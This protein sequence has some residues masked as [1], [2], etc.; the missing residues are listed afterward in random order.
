MSDNELEIV[1]INVPTHI[2]QGES[3]DSNGTAMIMRVEDRLV[4]TMVG[5]QI[6]PL[7]D[8]FDCFSQRINNQ[9]SEVLKDYQVLKQSHI[10]KF[11]ENKIFHKHTQEVVREESDALSKRLDCF[12]DVVSTLD[13][14][15]IKGTFN[16]ET[17]I[18]A[19]REELRAERAAEREAEHEA[20]MKRILE[21]VLVSKGV[22]V[23]K[24]V[25]L[26]SVEVPAYPADAMHVD[27]PTEL[28]VSTTNTIVSESFINLGEYMMTKYAEPI[29]PPVTPRSNKVSELITKM[30][31]SHLRPAHLNLRRVWILNFFGLGISEILTLFRELGLDVQ[32]IAEVHYIK[33]DVL[34]ILIQFDYIS[35]FVKLITF[36]K[37]K[38]ETNW[39]I[40]AN[41]DPFTALLNEP[42]EHRYEARLARVL[43]NRSSQA[44]HRARTKHFYAALVDSLGST[45]SQYALVQKQLAQ[46]NGEPWKFFR[47]VKAPPSPQQMDIDADEGTINKKEYPTAAETINEPPTGTQDPDPAPKTATTQALSPLGKRRTQHAP[48]PR[49]KATLDDFIVTSAHKQNHRANRSEVKLANPMEKK[50]TNLYQALSTEETPVREGDQEIMQA[51][52]PTPSPDHCTITCL[53]PLLVSDRHNVRS[54]ITPAAT[55]TNSEQDTAKPSTDTI[56]PPIH[57]PISDKLDVRSVFSP[58]AT[59]TASEQDTAKSSTGTIKPPIHLQI[60][61]Q[62]DVRTV[63]SLAATVTECEQGTTE[64]PIPMQIA[65]QQD[66]RSVISPASVIPSVTYP[67]LEISLSSVISPAPVPSP[68]SVISSAATVSEGEQD[69]T[70]P[71]IYLPGKSQAEIA[72]PNQDQST[73]MFGDTLP[74]Y[75]C[76]TEDFFEVNDTI[77]QTPNITT[78]TRNQEHNGKADTN[79]KENVHQDTK[80]PRNESD[81]SRWQQ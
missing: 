58:T 42:E 7:V 77:Q 21:T 20:V 27:G 56:T 18:T 32:K 17:Q 6:G 63:I 10:T 22:E 70:E 79:N 51:P 12:A 25:A 52:H 69:T 8:A 23:A 67:A 80:G 35:I 40:T 49:A 48:K 78:P 26:M 13:T 19:L 41:Y 50:G 55:V 2:T 65:H 34:E 33:R 71:S 74:R 28:T 73:Q 11:Y 47:H 4:E 36:I 3:L 31:T 62:H 39:F 24:E 29:L 61:H 54:L 15:I 16:I 46:I 59:T 64:P 44:F 37:E 14:N 38:E 30:K 5:L 68:E 53:I 45:T 66:N 81:F 43:Y 60:S 57:L 9:M 76:A 75:K 1:S 72:A